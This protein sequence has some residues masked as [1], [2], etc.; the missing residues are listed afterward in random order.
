MWPSTT[1]STATPSAHGRSCVRWS[2]IDV[3]CITWVCPW[4][5]VP[6][7]S[8]SLGTFHCSY[9]WWA[10]PGNTGACTTCRQL[11]SIAHLEAR[12]PCADWTGCRWRK[13]KCACQRT[14]YYNACCHLGDRKRPYQRVQQ[15][16]HDLV[17]VS[18]NQS[19]NVLVNVV[20]ID[21]A[22]L[23]HFKAVLGM[24]NHYNGLLE[25][26]ATLSIINCQEKM[27]IVQDVDHEYLIVFIELEELHCVAL[28]SNFLLGLLVDWFH[29]MWWSSLSSSTWS[30]PMRIWSL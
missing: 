2:S 21:A 19:T 22:Q 13:C 10:F 3:T 15:H 7:N 11:Q 24:T 6:T 23:L 26:H 27:H 28:Q 30:T 1:W 9:P 12:Q 5:S 17:H 25:Q 8:S 14:N 20:V 18:G 16:I 29:F 4:W